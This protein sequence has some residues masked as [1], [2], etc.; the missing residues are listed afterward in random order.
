[1]TIVQLSQRLVSRYLTVRDLA[2]LPGDGL[3]ALVDAVNAA[4]TDFYDAAPSDYRR[5]T[6]AFPLSAPVDLVGV[7]PIPGATALAAPAFAADQRACTVQVAG[8]ATWNE[9]AAPDALFDNYQGPVPP[10]AGVGAT[11]F[12]DVVLFG[13]GVFHALVSEPRL[14]DGEQPGE[15][16]IRDELLR[17]RRGGGRR[18]RGRPCRYCVEPAGMPVG[19]GNLFALRVDP[20]PD[21]AYTLR[22]ECD[23]RPLQFS[24]ADAFLP[25][26]LPVPAH[27]CLTGLLPLAAEHLSVH[28]RRYWDPA[29][30]GV[31]EVQR[32]AL[33][34]RESLAALPSDF[35][36]PHSSIGTP[37]G[38]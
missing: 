13:S 20:L 24:P 23:L 6:L 31:A 4:L 9:V 10:P 18:H 27:L 33:A 5:A 7:R 2:L 34:A 11:V 16:L 12:G 22:V 35:G 38:W 3:L 8:D 1:M 36:R 14:T 15:V 28:A 19:V 29:G 30:P 32:G 26:E 17:E 25:L 21:R 37:P